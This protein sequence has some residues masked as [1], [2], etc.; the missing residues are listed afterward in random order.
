MLWSRKRPG[1]ADAETGRLRQTRQF[2]QTPELSGTAP[3]V[4]ELSVVLGES[5]NADLTPSSP[6]FIPRAAANEH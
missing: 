3:S 5:L 2:S 6:T 4:C 1:R